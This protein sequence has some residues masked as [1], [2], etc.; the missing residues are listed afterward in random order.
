MLEDDLMRDIQ[1]AYL[2]DLL[3]VPSGFDSRDDFIRLRRFAE[4]VEVHLSAN[5]YQTKSELKAWQEARRRKEAPVQLHEI[6]SL[7]W[8]TLEEEPREFEQLLRRMLIVTVCSM[9]ETQFRLC[10]DFVSEYLSTS[11]TPG[12]LREQGLKQSRLYLEKIGGVSFAGF[13]DTW[14][15]MVALSKLRN[16]FVHR[17]APNSHFD[18]ECPK[19]ELFGMLGGIEIHRIL[20]THPRLR[21]RLGRE[22]ALRMIGVASDLADRVFARTWDRCKELHARLQARCPPIPP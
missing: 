16:L 12:D 10:C 5:D 14:D 20:L 4:V 15:T 13:E 8:Y 17:G 9:T 21:V 6:H 18:G 22:F 19:V 3:K 7:D 11:I 1:S 2:A